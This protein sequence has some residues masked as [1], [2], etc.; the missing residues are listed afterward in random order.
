LRSAAAQALFSSRAREVSDW[1]D[2]VRKSRS[3]RAIPA[4]TG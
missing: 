2:V 1:T 3:R 4:I